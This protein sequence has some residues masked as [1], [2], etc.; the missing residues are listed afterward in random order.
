M[1]VLSDLRELSESSCAYEVEGGRC[2]WH[3]SLSVQHCR[4]YETC[5]MGVLSDLRELKS[6][7]AHE[8]DVALGVSHSQ[9]RT[10]VTMR[11]AQW[12]LVSHPV[13]Q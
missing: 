5:L 10:A 3:V 2:A 1:E 7:C 12:T 6:S 8:V 4:N 11:H 9:C 13:L